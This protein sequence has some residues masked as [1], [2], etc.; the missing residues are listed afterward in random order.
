MTAGARRELEPASTP[1]WREYAYV[2]S[3]QCRKS[4]EFR[5]GKMSRVWRVD[6]MTLVRQLESSGAPASGAAS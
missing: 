2:Q 1:W 5:D 4:C 6:L 3:T